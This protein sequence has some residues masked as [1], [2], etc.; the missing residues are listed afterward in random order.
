VRG[1]RAQSSGLRAEQAA[2]DALARDG[3]QVLGR[4]VRT[5]AGEI[6]ILAAQDGL[7]AV[8]EVK[9]RKTLVAAI[10]SLSARQRARLML[11]AEIVM[12][13]N[14]AWGQQ[15]VRFDV[16]VVDAAFTIRR[17]TDAFRQEG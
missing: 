8:I 6:D 4:R 5:A 15:G 10:V 7:L 9:H 11:A 16:I 1:L 3:W 14:P 13:E 12:G 2:C 17:V